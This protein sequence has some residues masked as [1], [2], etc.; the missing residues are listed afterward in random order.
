MNQQVDN[1]A[2]EPPLSPAA[3]EY[4]SWI[5]EIV[6]DPR[7]FAARLSRTSAN[8][9]LE[10][11]RRV[12]ISASTSY[13]SKALTILISFV[14]VPLTVHYLGA[15][16]YG[17]WLTMSSLLTWISMTDFGLAG[18]ALVNAI[19]EAH[20]KDDRVLAQQYTAS[21]FW[22]LTVLSS[23]IGL[24]FL[25]AFQYISWEAVFHVSDTFPRHE[26]ELACAFTLCTFVAGLPLNMLNSIYNAYQDGYVANL[27][28]I[29]SNTLALI[30]LVVVSQFHGG[31]APLVLAV[32]GTRMVVSFASALYLFRVRYPWLAPAPS[33]VRWP[34]IKRLFN[35]GSKYMVTQLAGLGIYQSQPFI[36]TQ[37]LGPSKVMIF[38]V[39]LKIVALPVDLAYIGTAPFISAFAEAKQRQ[40]WHWVRHAFRRSTQATLLLCL[41]VTIA[42]AFG[43]KTMVRLLAG[44]QAVPDTA[45][46]LWLCLYSVIGVALMTS[47]QLLCG[48]ERVGT[49]AIS[50]VAAAAAT[51]GFAIIFAHWWELSGVAFGMALAKSLTYF[52]LQGIP[53]WRLLREARDPAP[54][55]PA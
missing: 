47:G 11:Y 14:S 28:G 16:R 9:G 49:L 53:V 33:A 34:R 2:A 21:T 26:L 43:A 32:S 39:T 5:K 37:L 8:R 44:S 13:L 42:V 23:L 29:A 41:P 54:V 40:D 6:R 30:T 3:K 45:T 50:L 24:A 12:G 17:V 31:L 35:L 20:G 52:P 22:S 7:Q 51:I 4:A 38:V 15:E 55:G 25:I 27:W 36:I 10:R 48:V 19:S 46:V 18:N 1:L